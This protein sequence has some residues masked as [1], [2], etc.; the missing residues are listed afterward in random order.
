ME[1]KVTK[2]IRLK[3]WEDVQ[4]TLIQLTTSSSDVADEEKFLFAQLDGED[5]TEKQTFERKKQCRRKVTEW[6]EKKELF[7][8]MPSY[9]DFT[10]IDGNTTS[11]SIDGNKANTWIRVKQDVDLVLEYIVFQNTWPGT[12]W[13]ATDNRQT[14]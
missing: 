7:S 6:V 4:T 13:S 2:K 9:P 12:W 5:E 14:V 1:L 10:K 3:I 8:M 11:Y